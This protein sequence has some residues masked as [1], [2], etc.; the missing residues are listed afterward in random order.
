MPQYKDAGHEVSYQHA[1]QNEVGL[2]PE[3]RCQPDRHQRETVATQDEYV[4]SQEGGRPG[5]CRYHGRC[6]TSCWTRASC[7]CIWCCDVTAAGVDVKRLWR[8]DVP[9][10]RHRSVAAN[11]N[12]FMTTVFLPIQGNR[13]YLT[14]PLVDLSP[15]SVANALVRARAVNLSWWHTV[16]ILAPKLGAENRRRLLD[17]V[18]YRYGTR[19]FWYQI[20]APIGCVF[21]FVL[22]SGLVYTWPLR[23]PVISTG[24]CHC[25][26][27]VCIVW[28]FY[29]LLSKLGT[30][31]L[32]PISGVCVLSFRGEIGYAA[33]L[34]M[35]CAA[36]VSHL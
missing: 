9:W 29:C 22:I 11:T 1:G 31:K 15:L 3:P 6:T 35:F 13:I 33:S 25:F 24:R 28:W 20:L 4:Q 8:H 19:F 14:L 18:S 16:Q 2:G 12:S 34:D 27:F 17:C 21:Y 26:H 10:W 36:L 7:L 23:Q 32:A 30:E 5:D